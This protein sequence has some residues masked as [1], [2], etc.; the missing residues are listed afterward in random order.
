MTVC[1]VTCMYVCTR[2]YLLSLKTHI[3]EERR[4]HTQ[5]YQDVRPARMYAHTYIHTY[6]H[7]LTGPLCDAHALKTETQ[8]FS[9]QAT[10]ESKLKM[11]SNVFGAGDLPTYVSKYIHGRRSSVRSPY[12]YQKVVCLTYV[13]TH[14]QPKST[15]TCST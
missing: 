10:L 15:K 5:Q 13:R 4:E 3:P 2:M 9:L 14:T 8:G 7:I 6:V 12:Y 1:T 11:A